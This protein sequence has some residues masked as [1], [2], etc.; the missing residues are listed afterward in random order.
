MRIFSKS[1]DSGPAVALSVVVVMPVLSFFAAIISFIALPLA[2][3]WVVCRKEEEIL[4]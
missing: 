4:N 3:I 2:L 1:V